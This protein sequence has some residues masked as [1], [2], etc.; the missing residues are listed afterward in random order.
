MG[1]LKSWLNKRVCV[2]VFFETH[3]ENAKSGSDRVWREEAS[4]K[5]RK[6]QRDSYYALK[7]AKHTRNAEAAKNPKTKTT[8]AR[9]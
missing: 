9:S 5:A 2:R 7:R 4:R 6:L 8:N 1:K 3:Y